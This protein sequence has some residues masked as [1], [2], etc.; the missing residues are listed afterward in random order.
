MSFKRLAI[1]GGVVAL[2]T[3]P[4]LSHTS[5]S[6]QTNVNTARVDRDDVAIRTA[7]AQETESGDRFQSLRD[8]FRR[9]SDR[10]ERVA[11]SY[12]VQESSFELEQADLR[13]PYTL[14]VRPS[15]DARQVRGTIKLDGKPL[16][17][18]GKGVVKINL[19]PYLRK[20]RQ[21]LQIAGSYRPV[22]ASVEVTLEGPAAEIAQE[23]GGNGI[24]NQTIAIDVK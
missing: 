14:T 6:V 18:L 21:K 5:A 16:K 20:G 19:S 4:I 17:T 3:A 7:N 11:Q 8:L 15:A 24:L 22:G 9:D 2:C 10:G 12:S 23:M 1:L 13:D